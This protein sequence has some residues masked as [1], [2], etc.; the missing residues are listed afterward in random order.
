VVDPPAG[1]SQ[2]GDPDHFGADAATNPSQAGDN[3]TTTP[4]ILAPGDVFLNVDFGYQPDGDAGTIG[5][6]VWLDENADGTLDAGEA[7]IAGV[8]VALALD[9][10]N[11]GIVDPGEI[12]AV[13]TTDAAGNYLFTGLS[14]D[15]GDGDADYLVLVTDSDNVLGALV[16]TLGPNAGAEGNS[17]ADPY[18]VTLDAGTTENLTGDFGYAPFGQ[19]TGDGLIGD[20]LFF[21]ADPNDGDATS[22]A[23]ATPPSKASWSSFATAPMS[24]SRWPSPTPTAGT[25]SAIWTRT[26]STTPSS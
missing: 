15:D 6:T 7:G 18:A 16:K 25:T 24:S 11:D 13:D 23:T 4:V 2:T 8:T 12:I 26:T 17:Q 5:D 20:T 19:A 9:A 14:L 10:N 21:D 1:Y 3:R 22:P